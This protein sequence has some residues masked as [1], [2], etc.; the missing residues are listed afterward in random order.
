M[1]R[2]S[3]VVAAATQRIR[4]RSSSR[5]C[6]TN[7]IG[8]LSGAAP[9]LLISQRAA[10]Q[11]RP[12]RLRAG[13][14]QMRAREQ[15][16]AATASRSPPVRTGQSAGSATAAGHRDFL[17]TAGRIV[18]DQELGG[19]AALARR[20]EGHVDGAGSPGPQRPDAGL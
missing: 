10:Q 14:L 9:I 19:L 1:I 15:K 11:A 8:A 2:K 7:S 3:T 12:E 6:D 5:F 20:R 17:R 13:R 18:V 16:R 4:P